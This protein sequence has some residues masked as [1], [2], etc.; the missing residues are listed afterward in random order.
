MQFNYCL[1]FLFLYATFQAPLRCTFDGP[2]RFRSRYTYEQRGIP[3]VTRNKHAQTCVTRPPFEFG[4]LQRCTR[5]AASQVT[6]HAG[7][8]GA[9]AS[10]THSASAVVSEDGCNTV[11]Q[12]E[13]YMTAITIANSMSSTVILSS[14]TDDDSLAPFSDDANVYEDVYD[15][16]SILEESV[17]PVAEE[18][19]NVPGLRLGEPCVHY[20]VKW[21][22]YPTSQSSWIPVP[23]CS[24]SLVLLWRQHCLS[25]AGVARKAAAAVAPAA[26]A[27]A[28]A[29]AA[30]ARAVVTAPP[31]PLR[32]HA[33][34]PI[35]NGARTL[36]KRSRKRVFPD[37]YQP[38][39][40]DDGTTVQILRSRL[41]ELNP[42]C[43]VRI[44][45]RDRVKGRETLRLGCK[46]VQGTHPCKLQVYCDILDPESQEIQNARRYTRGTCAE[47]RCVCCACALNV[48]TSDTAMVYE[49]VCT[50]RLCI[51]CV[52]V[53]VISAVVGENASS[54]VSTKQIHCNY[55]QDP[56]DLH[57]VVPLL[58]GEARQAYQN[59]LCTV[60]AI[61]SEKITE[62]RVKR[63]LAIEGMPSSSG[64]PDPHRHHLIKIE[65]LI[66]PMCPRCKKF[67]PDFDGCCALQ[68]GT[69][70][71][72]GRLNPETGCGAHICAWCQQEC[73]DGQHCHQHVLQC[74]LNP[75]GELYPPNPH[76]Q[77]WHATSEKVGRNR[78]WVY[79]TTHGCDDSIWE[80]IV[81]QWPELFQ[82]LPM[83]VFLA[84]SKHLLDAVDRLAD[85]REHFLSN[86]GRYIQTYQDIKNMEFDAEEQT[87]CR[88]IVVARADAQSVVNAILALPCK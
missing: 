28:P 5:N 25:A 20:L 31:A 54:F 65:S 50:H 60:A 64:I 88:L 57:K 67:I 55:C 82:E 43:E 86:F 71:S 10:S 76:P 49:C 2:T 46:H 19:S 18:H 44:R 53:M 61:E 42:E 63:Q 13:N 37:L 4:E 40:L 15:A 69:L 1:L 7:C 12:N 72:S 59:A 23:L 79:V 51:T 30:V 32:R 68:C 77:S 66:L 85:D 52:S 75:T 45:A 70:S 9:G 21:A 83:S 6:A 33:A 80:K 47:N 16:E 84:F 17:R 62:A 36:T 22:G 26:A 87:I 14:G 8:A 24:K 58:T 56:L 11:N 78:V 34:A 73:V 35:P 39:Q 48:L 81:L 27:V 38:L 74:W 3:V 41:A 29:A